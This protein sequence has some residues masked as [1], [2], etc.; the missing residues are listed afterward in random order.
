MEGGET[1]RKE[2][3]W[4]EKRREEKEE[5]GEGRN[6]MWSGENE[7]IGEG[8][9]GMWSGENEDRG[10]EGRNGK[11]SRRMEGERKERKVE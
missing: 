9:N 4:R 1:R 6:G 2:I 8:R 3:S 11:W 10:G 5:R 7:D